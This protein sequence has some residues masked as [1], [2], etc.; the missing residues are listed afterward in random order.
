MG[1]FKRIK[2]HKQTVARTHS[3]AE[4]ITPMSPISNAVDDIEE[5]EIDY[6]PC[7]QQEA[8]GKSSKHV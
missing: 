3:A 1:F 6:S 4:P 8:A 7:I 2:F 5:D